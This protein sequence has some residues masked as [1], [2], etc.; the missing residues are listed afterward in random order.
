VR[1][2]VKTAY[3]PPPPP[4]PPEDP[5][6]PEPELEPGAVEEEEMAEVR[7]EPWPPAKPPK[8]LLLHREP[9]YQE[10]C[11]SFPDIWT[12]NNER[13]PLEIVPP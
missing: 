7:E 6:P 9:W 13:N 3:Q 5:P 2:A 8:L 11:A 1:R 12:I 4:P 10:G